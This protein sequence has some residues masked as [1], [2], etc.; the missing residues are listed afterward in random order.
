MKNIK[1]SQLFTELNSEDS[2]SVNGGGV[3]RPC[4]PP[5]R[6]WWWPRFW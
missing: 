3:C 2:A 5:Q 6:P 4:S 1:E